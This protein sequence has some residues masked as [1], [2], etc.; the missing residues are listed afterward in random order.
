M[1]LPL[2]LAAALAAAVLL[3]GAGAGAGRASAHCP[4]GILPVEP[5]SVAT[6]ALAALRR[7]DAKSRPLVTSAALATSDTAR[8]SIA[9]RECGRRVWQRTV[10]VSIRLRAFAPS[11]SLSSR[12]SFVGRFKTGYRVWQIAH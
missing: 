10:V 1:R 6:A 3:P 7:E 8:G 2:V 5:D 4:T 9:K 12:V 11:A